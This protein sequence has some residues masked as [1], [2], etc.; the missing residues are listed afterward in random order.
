MQPADCKNR[1]VPLISPS[2][3][4]LSW[5][6]GRRKGKKKSH[7]AVNVAGPR[8]HVFRSFPIGA[9]FFFFPACR[10]HRGSL[11]RRAEKTLMKGARHLPPTWRFAG[12]FAAS[13]GGGSG[14]L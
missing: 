2:A 13:G 12:S 5:R 10:R 6:K 9:S 1:G 11:G 8:K 3:I 4:P 14:G 7:Q